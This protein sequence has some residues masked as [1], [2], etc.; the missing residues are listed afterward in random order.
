MHLVS[1]RVS[2]G[3]RPCECLIIIGAASGAGYLP[4][5]KQ[6]IEVESD[7][8]AR[9]GMR[10]WFGD[11]DEE[12][13]IQDTTGMFIRSSDNPSNDKEKTFPTKTDARKRGAVERGGVER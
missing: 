3:V 11:E 6:R 7:G 2:Q 12:N 1:G 10:F 5:K 9:T 13:S 8:D 4:S